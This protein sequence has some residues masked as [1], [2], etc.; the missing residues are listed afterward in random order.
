M[1]ITFPILLKDFSPWLRAFPTIFPSFW[2]SG[3][4]FLFV[5]DG[6]WG[7]TDGFCTDDQGSNV[8]SV[9]L[10]VILAMGVELIGCEGR[11][12]GEKHCQERTPHV[13]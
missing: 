13:V 11:Q 10:S 4:P 12:R 7:A 2:N 6:Y 1:I 5:L 9:I 8:I 3:L